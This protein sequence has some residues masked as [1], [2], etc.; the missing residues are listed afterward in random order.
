MTL[1]EKQQHWAA[2]IETRKQS[3]L[4]VTAFCQHHEINLATFYYWS[5]KCRQQTEPQHLHPVVLDEA[6]NAGHIVTLCLPNGI[7]AELPAG[8]STTQIRHWI[9][10]LR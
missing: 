9:E 6:L 3:G 10:A 8:L 4:T 2:V 5:K 1:T 7:R